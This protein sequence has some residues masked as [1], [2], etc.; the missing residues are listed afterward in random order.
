MRRQAMERLRD[1]TVTVEVDTNKDT[2]EARFSLMED[3]EIIGLLA[4]VRV[5]LE[6]RIPPTF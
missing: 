2:Y 5:W 4:R 1:I 3:E 6:N